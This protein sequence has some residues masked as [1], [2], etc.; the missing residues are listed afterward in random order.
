ME[1]GVALI[2]AADK[3]ILAFS[4][5]LQV[6]L[7]Q[8]AGSWQS[9][10]IHPP[11][12]PEAKAQPFHSPVLGSMTTFCPVTEKLI[13][14]EIEPSLYEAVPERSPVWGS[15]K[16]TP[17]LFGLNTISPNSFP[18]I[19][20]FTPV[21]LSTIRGDLPILKAIIPGGGLMQETSLQTLA[22]FWAELSREPVLAKSVAGVAKITSMKKPMARRAV[23][24]FSI[25]N[26]SLDIF[27]TVAILYL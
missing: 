3:L 24:E 9:N 2:T 21:L 20:P 15:L 6:V 4:S 22:V 26:L 13:R 5:P 16:W 25:F 8:E 12:G 19:V 27:L 1:A 14:P 10:F 17:P 7:T 23:R 11:L 18:Q